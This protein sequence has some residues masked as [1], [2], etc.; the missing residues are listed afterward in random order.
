MKGIVLENVEFVASKGIE[1]TS[2]LSSTFK[3]DCL[4]ICKSMRLKDGTL[5]NMDA[6]RELLTTLLRNND[7]NLNEK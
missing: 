1:N 7:P 2:F 5:T 4:E 3:A 6:K